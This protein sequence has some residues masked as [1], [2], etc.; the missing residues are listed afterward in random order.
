M[1][2]W[3]L[4]L[5]G[6]RWD[7]AARSLAESRP[8]ELFTTYVPI[9]LAPVPFGPST[10][11]D[12]SPLGPSGS[13]VIQFGSGTFRVSTVYV[14]LA[15]PVPFGP[16]IPP[17]DWYRGDLAERAPVPFWPARAIGPPGQQAAGS[18]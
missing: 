15:R 14:K 7:L 17:Q 16:A 18:L 3:G 2:V 5:E 9:W 11:R 10:V 1:V 13:G 12:R 6:A 4:Y 8:K